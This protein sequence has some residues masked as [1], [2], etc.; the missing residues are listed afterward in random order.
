MFSIVNKNTEDASNSLET[1]DCNANPLLASSTGVCCKSYLLYTLDR[2]YS[3][4]FD[5]PDTRYFYT[6]LTPLWNKWT[7]ALLPAL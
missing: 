3:M 4:D 2:F 6:E 1:I 5:S 7:A